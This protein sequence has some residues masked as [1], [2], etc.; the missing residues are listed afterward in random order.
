[1]NYIHYEIKNMSSYHVTIQI[2]YNI[3]DYVLYV[4]HCIT[5]THL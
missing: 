5:T 4:V 1:M 2:H 3:I